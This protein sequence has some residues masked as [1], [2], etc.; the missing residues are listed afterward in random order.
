[1]GD[2]LTT[3]ARCEA[4]GLAYDP[5]V[6]SGCVLCRRGET[7]AGPEQAAPRS[8][9]AAAIVASLCVLALTIC[10]GG[11]YTYLARK[12]AAI[13]ADGPTEPEVGRVVAALP[14]VEDHKGT[15]MLG[16]ARTDE[17][18]Y[19]KDLPDKLTLQSLLRER[20]FEEL[21]SHLESFQTAAEEDFKR[22]KWLMVGLGAFD[23]ADR[24]IG[25]LIDQ[26]MK[27]TPDS[28]AP[29]L[30]RAEHKVALAWHYRGGK[31]A[32]LT[33]KKRFAKMQ[34]ILIP[35][36]ADVD[37]ALELRPDST[38]AR[39]AQLTIATGLDAD[40][41]TKTEILEAG[42][43]HCP[44]CFGI[45]AAYLSTIVPRWGGAHEL[46]DVKAADWQ[47]TDKNPKL[48][49]L[50]GFADL[51]RCNLLTNEEPDKA[52]SYC[53]RALLNGK[54]AAFLSAK[55][56]ALMQLE[57]YDEA[58]DLFTQALDILPQS[59]SSLSGRGYAL[60]KAERYDEATRDLVLATR[61]DPVNA[62]AEKNLHHILAKLVRV[63]YYQAEVGELDAAIAAYDR[64]LTM[65]PNYADA[66]CYRGDA[67]DKM[68]D[69]EQ[70][71]KDYLKAIELDPR[72]VECYR[73]LDHVLVQQKR[74][75]EV[76]RLWNRYLKRK[77]KDAT[78]LFERSGTYYRKGQL[79]LAQ[80]DISAACR[81]GN[82]EACETHQRFYPMP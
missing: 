26:W 56:V 53:D 5:A 51:D 23:T 81:L 6:H 79:D 41:A 29:Y 48:K 33:S 28:F 77:P 47:F 37:R 11:V 68:G 20:R 2:G 24:R 69:L 63:A 60:L 64:V 1:M 59:V 65:H 13:E 39:S 4:H 30:A 22:E 75:D 12:Q 76:V 61:L 10:A 80:R 38:E 66:F 74:L 32:R 16:R 57:R 17:Y 73:G 40:V 67:Y 58:I 21:S 50:L 45:R 34:K 70:A 62:Q 19:P 14:G 3:N 7:E 44:Y 42:L 52:L 49:Q 25:R 15:I 46:M 8:L 82:K 43:R 35:A 72:N 54:N 31:W 55:A 78:A 9:K 71:E 36:A 27:A 18:G